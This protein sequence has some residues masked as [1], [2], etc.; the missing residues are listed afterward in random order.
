MQTDCFKFVSPPTENQ[1]TTAAP[2][3]ARRA[4]KVCFLK[5]EKYTVPGIGCKPWLV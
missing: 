3:V 4:G 1:E 2:I 5:S